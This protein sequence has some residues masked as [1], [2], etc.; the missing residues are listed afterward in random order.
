MPDHSTIMFS[1]LQNCGRNRP[2]DV[3]DAWSFF[4]MLD[5]A[6]WALA[7]FLLSHLLIAGSQ[8]RVLSLTISIRPEIGN[9]RN[10][11]MTAARLIWKS[12]SWAACESV[13]L[14]KPSI[15]ASHLAQGQQ[16][17]SLRFFP[18]V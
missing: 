8:F 11:R 16:S 13:A 12:F 7:R 3:W 4:K 1:W 18:D 10:L 15:S 14:P 2:K 9:L 17:P 6:S 5:L